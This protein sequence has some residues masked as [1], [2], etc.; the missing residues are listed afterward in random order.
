MTGL[1]E[2][3]IAALAVPI[4][5]C[6]A[7]G[8]VVLA[9]D[10][11]RGLVGASDALI[12]TALG[13]LVRTKDGAPLLV[14]LTARARAR[15]PSPV[16]LALLR[17]GGVELDV[18]CVASGGDGAPLVLAFAGIH[19]EPEVSPRSESYRLIFE[20]APL[21]ILHFD[22]RG[23][24]TACNQN[25]VAIIGSSRAVLVGLNML[26]L[27]DPGM[28]ACVRRALT[29]ELASY[30]GRYK[31]ATADKVT[32]VSVL[33]APVVEDG[34]VTGG[35]GIIRDVTEAQA[36]RARLAQADRLA[37]L[38]TLA[39]G[40]AHEINNPLTYL[41]SSVETALRAIDREVEG[42][43][44]R[45]YLETALDGAERIRRIVGDLRIFSRG[46][47]RPRAPIDV[48]GVLD[49]AANLCGSVMKHRARLIKSYG[50]LPPVW[51]DEVRLGQVF[52]NLLV[53]AAHAIP[54][55]STTEH[56][57]SV[58][59]ARVGDDRVSIEIADNGAGIPPEILPHIF[60]PF[61]TTKPVGVGTGLG[62]SICHS[63]VTGLG[64]EI[65]VE[66]E[67]GRGTTVRVVLPRASGVQ[68][69]PDP[70]ADVGEPTAAAPPAAPATRLLLVDDEPRLLEALGAVLGELHHQ[71]T[72]A[73]SGV[74]AL[75]RVAGDADYDVI[76]C[77]VMMPGKNGLDVFEELRRT[78]PA[79][80]QRFVF[81]SG[82]VLS[83]EMARALADTG[84]PRLAKPF[85]VDQ[86]EALLQAHGLRP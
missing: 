76:L 80:A 15:D 48:H 32:P 47:D 5:A 42:P 19:D 18:D 11:L 34:H 1:S 40:V 75:A 58:S 35:V 9:N 77:D 24:I 84:R 61:V 68:A 43:R 55:R 86:L 20:H 46:E 79:L 51:A 6:D 72:T 60:E 56:W 83:A 30:E 39:A 62:L 21:G 28:V 63:I 33:F 10:A 64:G 22:A 78:R 57:I 67:L 50:E 53:N 65:S 74:E 23:V 49:A 81:M 70:D 36:L 17:H 8:Q 59:T 41:M 12:G 26:S 37:S 82:G 69:R 7:S 66:S 14:L 29:G 54:E 71:V 3:V 4:L 38:G 25:F 73:T 52:V 2:Q 27:P 44:L 13:E 45:R 85:T 16:R 31:S